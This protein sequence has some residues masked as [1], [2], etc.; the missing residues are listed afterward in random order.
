MKKTANIFLNKEITNAKIKNITVLNLDNG[1]KV[2]ELSEIINCQKDFYNN[3]YTQTKPTN[4]WTVNDATDY[5]TKDQDL[6]KL[7]EQD[8]EKLDTPITIEE[9]CKAV[10]ALPNG[11]SP[12]TDGIPVDLHKLFWAKI[13]DLVT[14]SI[15]YA[16]LNGHMSNDQ[17]SGI[18]SL[19]PKK[20]KD[21]RMLKNWWPL[22][23]L[24]TDYKVYAKALATRCKW[25]YHS[26][27]QQTSRVA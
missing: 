10:K 8:N 7:Y 18:L 26:W 17:R 12:G 9:I 24:N 16:I 20:D 25:S 11:K 27:C 3:L 22:T 14:D 1:K 13:K 4:P 21:I 2:T 6:P 15:V 23:L 5:F 19:I